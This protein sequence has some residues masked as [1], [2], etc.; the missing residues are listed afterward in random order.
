MS[1]RHL[2]NDK[3]QM[4]ASLSRREKEKGSPSHK[5]LILKVTEVEEKERAVGERERAAAEKER[6]VG[7]RERK[8]ADRERK[9]IELDRELKERAKAG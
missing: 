9:F 8:L 7:E 1:L 4:S 6:V 3:R 5:E 2:E